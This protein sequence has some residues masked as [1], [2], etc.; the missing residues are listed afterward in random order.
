MSKPSIVMFCPSYTISVAPDELADGVELRS[1]AKYGTS[2]RIVTIF[3]NC[4][5]SRCLPAYV[6]GR[7]RIRSPSAALSTAVVIDAYGLALVPS[8]AVSLPV[9]ATQRVAAWHSVDS[10]REHART[11]HRTLRFNIQRLQESSHDCSGRT[12]V[13][14]RD[15][16][17]IEMTLQPRGFA[18]F[19]GAIVVGHVLG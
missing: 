18:E 19:G 1:C 12:Q 13:R 16:V 15:Q 8:P 17:S 10:S 4:C 11:I 6:P 3:E 14:A 9:V 5:L 2:E 7:T